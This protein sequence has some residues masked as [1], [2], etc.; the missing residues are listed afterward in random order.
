ME[1]IE[2]LNKRIEQIEKAFEI[3]HS[4]RIGKTPLEVVQEIPEK[5][6]KELNDY[7]LEYRAV[8]TPKEYYSKS[9]EYRREVLQAQS[10]AQLCK[11]VIFRNTLHTK[12]PKNFDFEKIDP[13]GLNKNILR[14]LFSEYIC[15]L[16]QYE[17]RMEI[18]EIT[19]YLQKHPLNVT[20]RKFE[21]IMAD[22]TVLQYEHNAVTPIGIQ[23]PM[24]VS[25][26]ILE[27]DFFWFGGGLV[28]L[29]I[30]TRVLDFMNI[31]D[32]VIIKMD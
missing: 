13:M 19:K 8:K 25:S 18:S 22:E 14:T 12:P 20:N 26:G 1:T 16:V 2:F 21:F 5:V 3:D 29:K 6:L 27:N 17:K 9:L 10:T 28:D 32:P 4:C 31:Y 24:I 11:S 15:V 23:F 7:K 30:G